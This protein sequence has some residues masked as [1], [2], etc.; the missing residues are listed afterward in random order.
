MKAE[1]NFVGMNCGIMD[2]FASIM[3]QKDQVIRLNCQSLDY[4]YFPF[5]SGDLSLVLCDTTVKH[6][7]VDS[8]YNQRRIDCE[9]GF[10]VLKQYFP[11]LSTLAETSLDRLLYL[12]N[13]IDPTVFKRCKYVIEE[14]AR[15]EKAC[16]SIQNQD[17]ITFGQLMFQTHE[18]LDKLYE[19][20]CPEANFLVEQAAKHPDCLGARM[21]GAGFG[22]CT[23]NLIKRDSLHSFKTLLG[24]QYKTAFNLEMNFYLAE[25][26][27]GV[28]KL[29][30]YVH[31]QEHLFKKNRG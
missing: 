16:Q 22:G 31:L 8:E 20:R 24:G 2:M 17:F 21:M 4:E 12:K 13:E 15:V 6:N 5:Q 18:G 29:P 27:V 19:V 26:S 30:R 23:L 3:G 28:E 9:T 10:S 11:E 25:P 7:L 14:S 1:N